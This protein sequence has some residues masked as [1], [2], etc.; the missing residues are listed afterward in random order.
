MQRAREVQEKPESLSVIGFFTA[1]FLLPLFRVNLYL[2]EAMKTHEGIRPAFNAGLFYPA[3]KMVLERDLSLL[4]ENSPLVAA[5]APIKA[6]VVP[7]GGYLYSGGVAARAYRQVMEFD[8]DVA[9]VIG[10]PHEEM[11]DFISVY[12]GSGFRTPVGDLLVERELVEELTFLNPEIQRSEMGF[13]DAEYTIEVQLPFLKWIQHNIRIIPIVIGQQ[14]YSASG[15][16]CRTLNQVLKG[17]K[18]LIVAITDLSRNVPD[19][20]ARKMDNI[21]IE[22]IEKFNP[23][24][25]WED[26]LK[27]RCEMCGV[28]AVIAAMKVGEHFGATRSQV[29]LYRNTGDISG[30]RSK[31][32]GYTSAVVY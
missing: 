1:D 4:L 8:Y 17:K 11:F 21:A 29:L 3:D 5:E 27:G 12:P 13:S 9:V 32:V 7:H 16:L 20:K 10:H 25:L 14:D 24:L 6:I 18:F 23:D 26:V 31:V 22:D 19:D 30:D 15:S 2:A 28:S